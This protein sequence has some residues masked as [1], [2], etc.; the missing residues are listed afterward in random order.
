MRL[1]RSR[2]RLCRSNES[3]TLAAPLADAVGDD[4]DDDDDE[5]DEAD[6]DDVTTTVVRGFG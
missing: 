3:A 4:D 1:R 5:A 2:G 6:D